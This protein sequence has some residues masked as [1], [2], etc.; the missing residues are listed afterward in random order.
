MSYLL[1]CLCV[2]LKPAR[3]ACCAGL[4]EDGSDTVLDLYSGTGTIALSLATRCK[5]VYG[6]ESNLEAIQDACFN[7][8]HNGLDNARFIYADLSR[9]QGVAAV[10][11]DVPRPDVVIAGEEFSM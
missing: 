6:V 8:E 1:T 3:C 5:Q 4:K 10:R 7:V 9:D 2:P 11:L